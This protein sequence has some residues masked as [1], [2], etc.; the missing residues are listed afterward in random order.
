MN[1]SRGYLPKALLIVG[2][3][4][5]HPSVPVV[6]VESEIPLK[7]LVVDAVEDA[8]E[9]GV[10]DEPMCPIEIGD[11]HD[12]HHRDAAPEPA[13]IVDIG[14]P[15]EA[16]QV[17][18]AQRQGRRCDEPVDDDRQRGPHCLAAHV[19]RGGLGGDDLAACP[20]AAAE[21]VA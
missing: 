19:R 10:M 8:K 5:A 16:R 3:V 2:V 9:L 4:R 6:K 17:G 1:S 15:V 12:Y 11:V 18:L 14:I 20:P 7:A 21:H 13:P